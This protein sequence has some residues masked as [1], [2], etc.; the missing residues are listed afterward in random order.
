MQLSFLP[1]LIIWQGSQQPVRQSQ[2]AS[3]A[4]QGQVRSR[5]VGG[6]VLSLSL[7]LFLRIVYPSTTT[8]LP[9]LLCTLHNRHTCTIP[10]PTPPHKH[11]NN[12]YYPRYSCNN[13]KEPYYIQHACIAWGPKEPNDS[14]ASLPIWCLGLGETCQ[15]PKKLRTDED[16]V[17]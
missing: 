12:L 10:L 11:S 14:S 1:P 2:P 16:G 5:L 7:F 8:N 6:G 9:T 3:P 13:H 17:E 4:K 15:Q